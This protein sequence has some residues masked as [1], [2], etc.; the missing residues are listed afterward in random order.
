MMTSRRLV[1]FVFLVTALAALLLGLWTGLLRLGWVL[2]RLRPGLALAHGPLMVS[3]FLGTL[4][5]L[6]R[7]VA[8]G[9]P[10]TYAVPLVTAVGT[11]ALMAGAGPVLAPAAIMLGGVVLLAMFAVI[12]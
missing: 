10:W 7:A 3:G 9:R 5:T 6:E 1:R 8:L 4:I 12:I 2:P 11:L